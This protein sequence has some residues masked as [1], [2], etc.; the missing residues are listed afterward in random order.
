MRESVDRG[1]RKKMVAIYS[2]VADLAIQGK[3]PQ[4]NR[5]LRIVA[6]RSC[7]EVRRSARMAT[8]MLGHLV[9]REVLDENLGR[10]GQYTSQYYAEIRRQ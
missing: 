10:F 5:L 3:Y 7:P 6:R 1:K 8:W 2:R 9:D 4:I